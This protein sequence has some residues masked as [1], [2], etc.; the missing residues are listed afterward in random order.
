MKLKDPR[1]PDNVNWYKITDDGDELLENSE[2]ISIE[3]AR[4]YYPNFNT[5]SLLVVFE[6]YAH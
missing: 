3:R 2:S 6:R 5:I 1:S 4:G